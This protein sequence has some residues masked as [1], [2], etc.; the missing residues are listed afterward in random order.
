MRPRWSAVIGAAALAVGCASGE[1][2][3]DY[4]GLGLADQWPSPFTC[5]TLVVDN[6][7][8][9]PSVVEEHAFSLGS[10]ENTGSDAV[11]RPSMETTTDAT[12][13]SLSPTSL[14]AQPEAN[15]ATASAPTH[16]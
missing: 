3:G 1:S 16:P 5:P 2:H 15:S 14:A 7:T 12:T 4:S 13:T 9:C 8:S 11:S 10:L 6:A